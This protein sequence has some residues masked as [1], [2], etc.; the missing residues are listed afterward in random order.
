MLIDDVR[1][2]QDEVQ[3]IRKDLEEAQAVQAEQV[4]QQKKLTGMMELV[5]AAITVDDSMKIRLAND[6]SSKKECSSSGFI[7]VSDVKEV[8]FND[9]SSGFNQGKEEERFKRDEVLR[10]LHRRN[11]DP[12]RPNFKIGLGLVKKT[13]NIMK[14]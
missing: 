12:S 2:G 1:W 6:E 11:L 14:I 8:N 13:V 5:Q 4:C 10:I 9:G 3:K 7:N